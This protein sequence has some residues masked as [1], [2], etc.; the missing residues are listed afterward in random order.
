[1]PKIDVKFRPFPD[2]VADLPEKIHVRRVSPRN[3]PSPASVSQLVLDAINAPIASIALPELIIAKCNE[4]PYKSP[5]DLR[6]I[7]LCDDHTRITPVRQALPPLFE[8]LLDSG[9]LQSN[10]TILVAGGS[11]RFMTLEELESKFGG[12]ILENYNVVLHDWENVAA[13]PSFGEIKTVGGTIEVKVNPLVTQVDLRIGVG[14]IIPHEIAGFAGGYKIIIPGISTEETVGKV[15]WLSTRVPVDERLGA[16]ANPVRDA[17]NAAGALVGLDFVVNTVL[18]RAGEVVGVFCGDP[19]R[20]HEEGCN[21]SRDIFAVP[22]EPAELVVTD[23]YPEETDFWT[24]SKAVIHAKGFVR[25]GGILIVCAAC[26]EGVCPNIW[27]V[28]QWCDIY[29]VTAGIPQ[30]EAESLGLHWFNNL[31]DAVDQALQSRP[32]VTD[33]LVVEYGSEIMQ[34]EKL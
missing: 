28:L 32:G 17:I 12:E 15:H 7:I 19:I 20:A 13:M 11:H 10:I 25:Q 4:T 23:C 6:V 22:A 24:S 9:I 14:N 33:L 34:G 29:L 27:E 3:I 31:Q 1:M 21:L 16:V 2:Q 8:I 26:P 30:G 18:N 5:Q